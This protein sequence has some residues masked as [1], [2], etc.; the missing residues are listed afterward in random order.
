MTEHSIEELKRQYEAAVSRAQQ[1]NDEKIAA[2]QRYTER[3]IADKL[4]EFAALGIT[5]GTKVR[6]IS[7]RWYD[8]K[9]TYKEAGFLGVEA[10]WLVGRVEPIFS[11]LKKDGTP[12]KSKWA[13]SWDDVKPLEPPVEQ[14]I[15]KDAGHG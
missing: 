6:L 3:L 15:Q 14:A 4:A 2:G 10:G 8:H 5:P 7:K 11:R 1:A 9:K 13:V 12:S